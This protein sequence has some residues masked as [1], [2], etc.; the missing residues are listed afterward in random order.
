MIICSIYKL[1][2][3]QIANQPLQTIQYNKYDWEGYKNQKGGV[4]LLK[5]RDMAIKKENTYSG[6]L[7]IYI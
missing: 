3:S 1:S 7:Y 6:F 4:Q 5:K 2:S